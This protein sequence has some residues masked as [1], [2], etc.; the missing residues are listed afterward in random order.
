MG[1]NLTKQTIKI[2]WQ[3]TQKHPYALFFLLIGVF[4]AELGSLYLPIVYKDLIDTM[5]VSTIGDYGNRT[6]LLNYVYQVGLV[7]L[8]IW[9]CWRINGF[10]ASF[11]VSKV[12]SNLLNTSYANLH[13]HS[14]SFFSNSFVGSLVT[15]V[16]RFSRAYEKIFD[17]LIW[18]IIP[19][20]LSTIIVL[21]VL[22]RIQPF[23]GLTLGLWTS[24]Y[25]FSNLMFIRYKL[26]YDL[27]NS[28]A[29]SKTTGLIADTI[30]NN[31]NLKLF[32]STD[33]EVKKFEQTTEKLSN[34]R[35]KAWKLDVISQGVHGLLMVILEFVLI[36]MAINY[37]VSGQLSIGEVTLILAYLVKITRNIWGVGRYLRKIYESL[38]DA[39]EMTTIL[40]TPLEIIDRRD[41]KKLIV[42]KGEINFSN[43]SFGY[44]NQKPVL[45]KFSLTLQPGERV[46]LIGKSGGGKT[47]I[48]KL[49]FRF[50]DLKS[51]KITIDEQDIAQVTQDSLR[52]N[53]ALVPQEPI[54]FHRSLLENIRYAKPNATLEQI[55]EASKLAHCHDFIMNFPEKYQTLVG[56]RGIKLSGGERQR[57]AIARAILKDSPILVLDEATSSLDSESERFI[58]DSLKRLM[59]GRTT[60]VIAHRLSTIMQ[61]DR[62]IVID[63]GKIVEQGTHSQLLKAKKGTYQKLWEIQAGSFTP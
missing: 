46:A 30:S 25:I 7:T 40:T 5:T 13:Q 10:S 9:I 51:G 60:L 41:A 56:E 32:A 59:K 47:T 42:T 16:N 34:I 15:K 62:I 31:I 12:L 45:N 20:L 26:K 38:A 4:G 36:Y 57:V 22:F 54:L 24:I 35:Y 6:I 55:I 14:Y 61:M 49:L 63:G 50:F 33:Y 44:D 27:Q 2:F 21:V 37:W 48:V 29:E 28:E 3:H 53:I 8:F 58:Q 11:L 19:T 52:L 17:E 18:D 1:K 43:L 39:E 23:F